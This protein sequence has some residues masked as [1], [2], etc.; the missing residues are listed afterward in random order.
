MIS[1]KK[2]MA[3]IHNDKSISEIAIPG[4]N[5]SAAL[6]HE[7][8]SENPSYDYE[9]VTQYFAHQTLTIREQ[10]SEGVRFLDLQ[11]DA[12]DE[13]SDFYL[14]SRT[15]KLKTTLWKVF[16]EVR[17]FLQKNR[18]ETV[19]ISLRNEGEKQDPTGEKLKRFLDN[20]RWKIFSEARIPK[21]GE[22]RGKI[23]IINKVSKSEGLGIYVPFRE[24]DLIKEQTKQWDGTSLRFVVD[25]R[26]DPNPQFL[27]GKSY[28]P[29][30]V[31]NIK[32]S[33]EW[34]KFDHFDKAT[35]QHW[36]KMNGYALQ[37]DRWHHLRSNLALPESES[38]DL[39]IMHFAVSAP[40]FASPGSFIDSASAPIT[41]P[42]D[43]GAFSEFTVFFLDKDVNKVRIVLLDYLGK[44]QYDNH[45]PISF[46]AS[47]NKFENR[48]NNVI[49]RLKTGDQLRTGQQLVSENNAFAA[50][51]TKKG[52]FVIKRLVDDVKVYRICLSG[53]CTAYLQLEKT[54]KL[55]LFGSA[56]F[57]EE[58][59]L[60]AETLQIANLSKNSN[61]IY[62]QLTNA[63]KLGICDATG[64]VIP[65]MEQKHQ[66]FFVSEK[67]AKE[68]HDFQ[69]WG[70]WNDNK[71]QL[72]PYQKI[73]SPDG[74]YQFVLTRI[75]YEI[76][77]IRLSG[78]GVRVANKIEVQS[79]AK[80]PVITNMIIS[81]LTKRSDGEE[82]EE[83][84][85]LWVIK[86]MLA[87]QPTSQ[88]TYKTLCVQ[89]RNKSEIVCEWQTL[90]GFLNQYMASCM[91]ISDNGTLMLRDFKYKLNRWALQGN[92]K[93]NDEVCFYKPGGSE[94]FKELEVRG[95]KY[96]YALVHKK[97]HPEL[98]AHLILHPQ[99]YQDY[100][101]S[102]YYGG[103][104]ILIN[105]GKKHTGYRMGERMQ[106]SGKVEVVETKYGHI[107][108]EWGH[109]QIII[110]PKGD[111]N[112]GKN[113][114]PYGLHVPSEYA[115]ASSSVYCAFRDKHISQHAIGNYGEGSTVLQNPYLGIN[116]VLNPDIYLGKK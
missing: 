46:I 42:L 31:Q 109:L 6:P 29:T 24:N 64:K 100:V 111:K 92:I 16:E 54:G 84:T 50:T 93:D 82:L 87:R 101:Y 114:L 49:R 59:I 76:L 66:D 68:Y 112:I 80:E 2:W 9:D 38:Y 21:L 8:R 4:S 36:K 13:F 53:A 27:K 3:N 75:G 91:H 40:P 52:D 83:E 86:R 1:M 56:E 34:L 85:F 15:L 67:G 72:Y 105:N 77:K 12:V 88:S 35:K 70:F 113:V 65:G 45:N 14:Y 79:L 33:K 98:Q 25:G 95:K 107:N 51:V 106:V 23:L 47:F 78:D 10:L 19:L 73:V 103:A 104:T 17:W 90:G 41:E 69:V 39:N 7:L 97:G 94:L 57:C 18:T 43:D 44:H 110:R 48:N 63:G 5:N 26:L 61:D 28:T 11:Y 81:V 99:V 30:E 20:E 58:V 22:V 32:T 89:F 37:G 74:C 108:G 62:L 60:Q 115:S 55:N 96:F 116:S 71:P 102:W